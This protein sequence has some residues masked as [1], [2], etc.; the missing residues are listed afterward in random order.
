MEFNTTPKIS[1]GLPV[2]NGERFLKRKLD[3]I[4][5]QT[6]HNF[7]LIISDN[8]STD[9][10]HLICQEYIKKDKRIRY[11]RQ[12][13]NIGGYQNFRFVLEKSQ[14]KYFVWTAVD[15]IILPTFIEKNIQILELNTNVV[16]SI[17]KIKMYGEFTKNLEPKETDSIFIKFKKKIQQ[18]FAHMSTYA[19]TGTYNSRVREYLKDIRHNQIFFGVYRTEEIKKCL[20]KESFL[21]NDGA[22]ILNILRCGE[23]FVVDEVLMEVYDGGISRSGMIGVARYMHKDLLYIL[24][25][26]YPFTKW[27]IRN[28]GG[29]IFLKNL[30]VFIKVN[31]IGMFSLVVDLMRKIKNSGSK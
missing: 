2:Y 31:C 5:C 15:D 25:P 9:K 18:N 20:V 28:L 16:C 8:A 26:M 21:W 29:I 12:D 10:T 11:F 17:S 14:A 27:C 13:E 1:L 3:S 19:A 22:T 23:L 30:D 24:F 6:F 7:E 4:L